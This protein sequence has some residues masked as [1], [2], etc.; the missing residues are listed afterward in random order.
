MIILGQIYCFTNI[1][2]KKQ[3]IGQ[4]IYDDNGRYNRHIYSSKTE[5]D[6]DYNSPLHGAI[7]KYGIENFTYEILAKDIQ[8]FDL[9]NFL[10]EYYIAEFNSQIP[11]GYNIEPGGK[12]ASRPKSLEQKIK[13]TWPQAKLTEQEIIE[14]RKAY[15]N[16]ESPKKIYEEKYKSRLHYN[17]FLNIWSGRRYANIMPEALEIGR[18]T[19]MTQEKAEELRR[20]YFSQK[21]S[22]GDLATKFGISK[23]TVADIVKNR[24]WKSKEPVSTIP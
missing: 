10:E 9:L 8:D 23:S 19:K 17:A 24:T 1:I 7:R 22:Y 5:T 12:N 11:N 15:Q 13:A 14:L 6:P 20:L 4:T 21:I 3:Y 16:K 18:H 2:N